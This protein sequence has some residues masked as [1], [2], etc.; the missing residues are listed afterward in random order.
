VVLYTFPQVRRCAVGRN[1][2]VAGGRP[3]VVAVRLSHAEAQ[4]LDALRGGHNRGTFLRLLLAR[5]EKPQVRRGSGAEVLFTG[6]G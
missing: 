5:A 4:S 3:V 1:P 6:E 2:S